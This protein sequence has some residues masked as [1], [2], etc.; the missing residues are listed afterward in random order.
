MRLRT[1][2]GVAAA[3]LYHQSWRLVMLNV[4]LGTVILGVLWQERESAATA[5]LSS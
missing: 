3:D 1:A 5:K 2:L 4:L